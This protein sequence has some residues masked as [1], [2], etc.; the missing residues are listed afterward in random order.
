MASVSD[1]HDNG[2]RVAGEINSVE[3]D[4]RS[5]SIQACPLNY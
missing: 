1:P 3:S 4:K 5:I 2:R